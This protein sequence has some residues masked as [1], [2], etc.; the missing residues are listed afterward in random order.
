MSGERGSSLLTREFA[1]LEGGE[2]VED[3]GDAASDH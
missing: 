2:A 3:E 1:H